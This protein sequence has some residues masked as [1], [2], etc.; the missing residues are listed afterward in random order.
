GTT[1][2]QAVLTNEMG[3]AAAMGIELFVVDAGWYV[4]AGT[5][6]GYD[7]ESGLGT[8]TEDSAR[9]PDGLSAL[10]EEAHGGGMTLG[11]WVEP[12]RVALDTVDRPDLAHEEWLA[13]RDGSYGPQAY[14]QICLV[15]PDARAWV[16]GRLAKP[17]HP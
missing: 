17:I 10:A 4:G 5:L 11:I 15:P 8:W 3:R 1:I 6:G 16:F 13:T 12:G 14:A 9:F 2:N 7:F